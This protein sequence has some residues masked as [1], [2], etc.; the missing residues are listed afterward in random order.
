MNF[1][2]DCVSWLDAKVISRNGAVLA[3]DARFALVHIFEDARREKIMR[4]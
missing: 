2:P 3:F 1:D 4:Y